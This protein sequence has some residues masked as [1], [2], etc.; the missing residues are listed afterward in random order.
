[1]LWSTLKAIY[2]C[3]LWITNMPSAQPTIPERE[4][5]AG[6]RKKAFFILCQ[7]RAGLCLCVFAS[8]VLIC[9]CASA[10]V[11]LWVGLCVCLHK[12]LSVNVGAAHQ[13][14]TIHTQRY[15][16]LGRWRPRGAEQK[17]HLLPPAAC[18]CRCLAATLLSV[19]R[20]A[21]LC[22]AHQASFYW[23]IVC[24]CLM[25]SPPPP[26]LLL[27]TLAPL[28]L[29]PLHLLRIGQFRAAFGQKKR[30]TLTETFSELPGLLGVYAIFLWGLRG[31]SNNSIF[32]RGASFWG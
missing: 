8:V 28:P 29:L 20:P 26:L 13:D 14:T 4:Q 1:M 22:P 19:L 27:A 31:G 24:C 12:D 3:R 17:E 9:E 30:G 10:S 6:K 2:L 23:L 5:G 15:R 25:P 18:R 16:E 32:K 7:R 11:C 21:C